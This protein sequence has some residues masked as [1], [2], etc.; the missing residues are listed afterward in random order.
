MNHRTHCALV[1]ATLR[2]AWVSSVAYV[3]LDDWT[4]AIPSP[5]F[6]APDDEAA[7]VVQQGRVST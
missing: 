2:S 7:Q 3:L 4:Q 1:G 5:A 6:P